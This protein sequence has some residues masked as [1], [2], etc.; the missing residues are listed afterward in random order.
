MYAPEA[1]FDGARL[2][3]ANLRQAEVTSASFDGVDASG[4]DVTEADLSA[5]DWSDADLSGATFDQ[6]DLSGATLSGADLSG[7]T[8][9]QATLKDADLSGADLTDVELSDTV[10]T[11]ALLRETRLAPETACGADFTEADLTGSDISSGQ[12]DDSTFH[13]ATLS[14][15]TGT[16]ASFVGADLEDA[17]LDACD[18]RR[19][20]FRRVRLHGAWLRDIRL[21]EESDFGRMCYYEGK[22][23]KA[24]EPKLTTRDQRLFEHTDGQSKTGAIRHL[25]G[26]VYPGLVRF[27][28]RVRPSHQLEDETAELD[29]AIRVYRTYQRI[30]R[31]NSLPSLSRRYYIRERH[32]QRKLA[33]TENQFTRWAKLSLQRWTMLYAEGA[34]QVVLT[35]MVLIFGFAILLPFVGLQRIDGQGVAIPTSG[36]EAIVTGRDL[37]SYSIK[38]FLALGGNEF[39]AIG[40]GELLVM[41]EAFTGALLLALLVFVLGRRA[42]R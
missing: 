20:D 37:L 21:D 31:E 15:V 17:A 5:T 40:W 2:T 4:I 26:D 32:A 42:T 25:L 6:A 38:N 12:F 41:V 34:A 24:L 16:D 35:S 3:E 19:T 30:F 7:A 8:F 36:L 39:E 28:N 18:L 11:G 1:E 13:E 33:L 14:D 29:D 23:D 27:T 10:L 22:S 9:N